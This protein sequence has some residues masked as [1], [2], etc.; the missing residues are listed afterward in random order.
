MIVQWKNTPEVEVEY[1]QGIF[2]HYCLG[3]LVPSFCGTLGLYRLGKFFGR[4]IC[5]V[6]LGSLT[7]FKQDPKLETYGPMSPISDLA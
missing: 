1:V 3:V 5:I 6:G 7:D 4:L 2:A